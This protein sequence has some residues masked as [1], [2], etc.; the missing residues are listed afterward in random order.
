M[1]AYLEVRL[2]TDWLMITT[3]EFRAKM[4][5]VGCWY[6]LIYLYYIGST[7]SI[8]CLEGHLYLELFFWDGEG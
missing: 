6:I 8:V 1:V 5:I 4:I 2:S 7:C 3:K